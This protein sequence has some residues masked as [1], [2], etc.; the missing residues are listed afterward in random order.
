MLLGVGIDPDVA[1]L[2][3]SPLAGAGVRTD[4]DGRSAV[5]DVYAA[6]DAAAVYEPLLGRHV[7][8]GHWE[9]AAR[10]GARAAKAMLGLDPGPA[11]VASF[12]S[13]LYGTRVQ[14]L[15]HASLADRVSLDGDLR[16]RDFAATFTTGGQAVAVLLAGRPHALPQARALLSC[17]REG[18][19]S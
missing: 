14:Y 13:D 4:V 5:P 3:D 6:G 8:A 12:W 7:P 16:S 10:Q 11:P 18:S 2:A 15:G 17:E 19:G 1:W 9:A